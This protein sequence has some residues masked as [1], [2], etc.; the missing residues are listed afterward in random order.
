[1]D[2]SD[3]DMRAMRDRL[4]HLTVRARVLWAV[5]V[6]LLLFIG[7]A[8]ERV[9]TTEATSQDAAVDRNAMLAGERQAVTLGAVVRDQHREILEVLL[10]SDLPTD[11]LAAGLA[12]RDELARTTLAALEAGPAGAAEVAAVRDAYDQAYGIWAGSIERLTSGSRAAAVA[13]LRSEGVAAVD[14]ASLATSDLVTSLVE[15]SEQAE[16]AAAA[17]SKANSRLTYL[18]VG[19]AVAISFLWGLWVARG[20]TRTLRRQATILHARSDELDGLGG[21]LLHASATTSQRALASAGAGEQVS[22]NVQTVATAVEELSASVQEIARSSG[23]ASQVAAEAVQTAE[24]TNRNVARLGES[25]AEIGEVLEVITAIAE[26]TNLLA[27]NATIEAAR[28]GEAGKGFAV[29]AGEVK[30][31]AKETAKATEDIASRIAAIRV[32]TDEA[33]GAIGAIGEVIGRIAD[34]QTT[35]A[36]AVEEQTA[37]T[38]EISRSIGEA[39]TGAAGI[40]SNVASVAQAADHTSEGAARS[41][42]AAAQLRAVAAGLEALVDGRRSSGI[43]VSVGAPEPVPAGAV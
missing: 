13:L 9:S 24:A 11:G 23:A 20:I 17:H 7:V 29:V 32:D 33:V 19:V 34:M 27:L 41:Q 31:L 18:M 26:Q 16:A 37:T 4:D 3:T 8:A 36:S 10:A 42:Q 12:T 22:T 30:E 35:I 2:E 28:A 25:S 15:R 21:E 39:A 38:G 1:M 6:V 14:Q 43:P 5:G 40:A